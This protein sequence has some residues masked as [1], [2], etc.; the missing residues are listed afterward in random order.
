MKSVHQ[1]VLSR[2]GAL[3][4][5]SILF[6][7]DF[8]GVGTD[9]AIKKALSRLVKDS[10]LERLAHGIYF[11]TKN[12]PT[13][14]KLYPSLEEVAEAVAEHEHVRIR[15]TGA[16]AL[17]KLGLSTQVPTR[18]VY[19]TDGQA[20]QIKVGKGGIK[21]KPTTPKK[22]GMKGPI[23]SLLIQALEELELSQI[24]PEMSTH[25]R[26]LLDKETPENLMEDIKLASAR[27]NDMLVSLYFKSSKK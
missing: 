16:Y 10:K 21:F 2:I 14:G 20:R 6:P 27:V 11:I 22:F 9:D 26:E 12:H 24:T 17:N 8:R 23:S 1:E 19:I 4:P 5:G 15:P 3:K 13:F 18:Q 25:I 7:T